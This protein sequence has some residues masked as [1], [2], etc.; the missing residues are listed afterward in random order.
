MTVADAEDP[1]GTP[2]VES[3]DDL[4]EN[5]P[6]GYLSTRPDGTIVR[7]NQTLLAFTGF[8]REELLGGRRFQDLLTIGGR[9]F[10]ETHLAPL[11]QMQ[12]FVNEI[13]LELIGA[14]RTPLPVLVGAVLRTDDQDR[15]LFVRLMVFSA[16]E[17]QA[18][19]RELLAARR[20][21]EHEAKAKA[22]FLAMLSHEIRTPLGVIAGIPDL[23]SRTNLTAQQRT[24]V[25]LLRSSS[26][27]LLNL[28]NDI[29]D[30]S[31]IEAGKVPLEERTL[32]VR[33]LV[34]EVA[35]AFRGKAD[36]KGL[37]LEVKLDDRL[38]PSLLG[39]P[40][41]LRQVLMN[42]VSNAIKFTSRGSVT[43]SVNVT[44][45]RASSV[46]LELAVADTGMGIPADRL[47]QLFQDFSQGSYDIG[48]RYGGTGL[49]LAISKRLLALHG[50]Q[51]S[52]T[53]TPG[54]GTTFTFPLSLR[55]STATARGVSKR[56]A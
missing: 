51:M 23:L 13:A 50:S 33:A 40:M 7:V 17:R 43:V 3:A 11:V 30:L 35:D 29:L 46:D 41:K 44:A 37:A 36:E 48:L 6:C 54:E 42:L 55:T 15:P 1:S 2:I 28:L 16:K 5:A 25:R 49:G 4:Y 39:D 27:N 56:G 20:R 32:D 14:E 19:E 21:A 31:K 45:H 22:A 52:V 18:Y 8:T 34:A 12:G 9:I 38:P 47:P 24:Y 26:E 53:S 10:Y